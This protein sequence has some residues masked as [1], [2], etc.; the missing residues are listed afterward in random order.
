ML[1]VSSKQRRRARSSRKRRRLGDKSTPRIEVVASRGTPRLVEWAAQRPY[2]PAF[3]STSYDDADRSVVAVITRRAGSRQL[4]PA[5]VRIERGCR[6]VRDWTVYEP[7]DHAEVEAMLAILPALANE[8]V[9]VAPLWEV[10]SV[11]L[12]AID[13]ADALG[14]APPAD[15]PLELF[16]PRPDAL[17]PTIG[18]ARAR[19]LLQLEPDDDE[20]ALS[21]HLELRVGSDG[22]DVVRHEHPSAALAYALDDHLTG[23]V[24]ELVAC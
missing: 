16:A 13:Y 9:R 4:V 11:L 23:V 17:V 6:G 10:Q 14:F 22:Y 12:S 5:L 18:A 8:P 20:A 3:I 7:M 1:R 19:P 15:F 21:A 24:L 2:G